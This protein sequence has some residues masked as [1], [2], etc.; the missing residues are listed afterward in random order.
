MEMGGLGVPLWSAM[1]LPPVAD[2][3]FR[4]KLLAPA[5]VGMAMILLL[6]LGAAGIIRD[7][8]AVQARL[9]LET[10]P[11]A[12]AYA[13]VAADLRQLNGAIFEALTRQAAKDPTAQAAAAALPAKADD[14]LVRLDALAA[15]A[16]AAERAALEDLRRELTLYQ[17][18]LSFVSTMMEID[19]KAAVDFFDPFKTR[20][21]EISV[22]LR[23]LVGVAKAHAAEEARAAAGA[24]GLARL[25]LFALTLLAML[26]SAA[27]AFSLARR[28]ADSVNRIADATR[29]LAAGD[30][31]TPV[32][33]LSRR[34]ELGAVVEGL[35]VF[36]ANARER[37]R[38][39]RELRLERDRAEAA[40]RAKS[41]FLYTMSHELRTPLNAIIGY[42]EILREGAE[43]D[44]R[45]Q[46]ILDADRILRAARHLLQLINDVL[47]LSKV[48]AGRMVVSLAPADLPGLIQEVLDIVR[49][50][51]AAKRNR[52]AAQLI[53]LPQTVVCD[54]QKLR[55]CLLNLLSNAVKFTEDGEVRLRAWRSG[56]VLAFEVQDTGIGIA[57]DA[58]HRLFR[59]FEQAD[60]S[61]TRRFGGTGLGLAITKRMA[62]LMGGDVV[63]ESQLG[64][65]STFRLTVKA[66]TP[67]AQTAAA[68][69]RSIQAAC[70]RPA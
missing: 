43:L 39:D 20:A 21:D 68:P 47:D 70:A 42:S 34:D 10:L 59:P 25:A 14:L 58:L 53:D 65:G 37:D 4:A 63:V 56:E 15:D 24:A 23:D 28:T 11:R 12:D 44:A 49:P 50:Q 2:W 41:E 1:R 38:L 66:L 30:L 29:E 27:V 64:A 26:V 32:E 17:G 22:A 55:Q 57:P 18:A 52:V 7:Q 31:E 5:A 9:A 36:R 40:N 19:F 45:D 51:A 69:N 61:T 46:D 3:S 48:E 16:D 60:A 6:A 35:V 62:V 67:A 54:S 13:Q 8:A 33:R